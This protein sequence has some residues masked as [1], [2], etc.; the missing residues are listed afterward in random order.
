MPLKSDLFAKLSQLSCDCNDR[1]TEAS[2]CSGLLVVWVWLI[3]G[4]LRSRRQIYFDSKTP[5]L[6]RLN[7]S[8]LYQC[9]LSLKLASTR[10]SMIPGTCKPSKNFAERWAV[11][12]KFHAQSRKSRLPRS[13]PAT[14]TPLT[15]PSPTPPEIPGSSR[16]PPADPSF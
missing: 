16:Y 7:L 5:K 14:E 6:S 8:R 15:S 1:G 10:R 2:S 4:V 9:R 12:S 3:V 13:N 11:P